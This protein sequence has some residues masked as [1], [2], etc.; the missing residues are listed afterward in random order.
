MDGGVG[1]LQRSVQRD[2]AVREALVDVRCDEGAS[3]SGFQPHEQVPLGLLV[4]GMCNCQVGGPPS[5]VVAIREQLHCAPAEQRSASRVL[6]DEHVHRLAD[7]ASVDAVLIDHLKQRGEF[8]KAPPERGADLIADWTGQQCV[9]RPE[10]VRVR[11]A[12]R[13]GLDGV[14]SGEGI[15]ADE[16]PAERD[17]RVRGPNPEHQRLP[18]SGYLLVGIGAADPSRYTGPE[19]RS[20][21]HGP[22]QRHHALIGG[23]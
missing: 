16:H 3:Q 9:L 15:E 21:P 17:Q 1:R 12:M 22:K 5:D 10:D 14:D 23:W 4:L 8:V 19:V 18:R 7:R 20:E 11:R 2:N 13:E 6:E